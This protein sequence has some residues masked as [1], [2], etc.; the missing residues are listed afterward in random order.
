[1]RVLYVNHTALM[2]GGERSL[3]TLLGALPPEV[4]PALAAPEGELT[5]AVRRLD[6]P[7]YPLGGTAGSLKLHP[8]HTPRA[9]WELGRDALALRSLARRLRMDV[10][11]ANSIRA[12]MI[13]AGAS[14][15]G[16]PPAV[17]HVR[18]C[19]PRTTMANATRKL[20]GRRCAAVIANSGYTERSFVEPGF[21][22]S[23]NVVHNPV[24][25][26]R[27]DPGRIDRQ[28]ARGRLGLES[29]ALVLAVVAQLTPWKAQDDAVRVVHAL[30][31]R[32]PQV[33]L[34]LVGAPKFVSGATRYDNPTFVRSLERLIDELGVRDEVALLGEREDVPEIMR[35]VDLVLVPSWEEPFGRSVGEAMA[36]GVPVAATSVGGPPELI[37]DGREGILLPPQQPRRWAEAI[38]PLVADPERRGAM[39]R[40]AL[41]RARRQ[42]DPARHADEV[43]A[44]Y[45]RTLSGASPGSRSRRGG[46]P[47]SP[48]APGTHAARSAERGP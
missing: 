17:A 30:K 25:L 10:V 8:L 33:R 22:A 1:M 39:G 42:L 44:V 48:A 38:E 4:S 13:A 7:V 12:G 20:I 36:M 18:D 14:L 28:E 19:L 2:S 27:F 5:A 43:L 46:R 37:S 6:I 35:A 23:S 40:A 21:R 3:L 26:E 24:D 45:E 32:H 15:L 29:S 41:A 34:L 9:A 11:H 47:R 31:Q 16:A